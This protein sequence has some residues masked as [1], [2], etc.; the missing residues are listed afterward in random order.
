M[1]KVLVGKTTHF[2]DKIGVAVSEVEKT[3]KEGDQ[4]LIEGPEDSFEQPAASMQIDRETIKEAK[5]GQAIGMKV[6][7][8]VKKGF[9]V[10]KVK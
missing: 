7:Q 5:K 10:F 9:Q 2:F 3:I 1:D 4:L 6:E 8:P